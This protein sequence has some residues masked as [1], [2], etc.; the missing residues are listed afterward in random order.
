MDRLIKTTEPTES[1]AKSRPG[2][3]GKG[4]RLTAI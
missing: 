1:D 4:L 2:R 3:K